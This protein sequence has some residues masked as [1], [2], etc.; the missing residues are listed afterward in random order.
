MEIYDGF[1]HE[2]VGL[3]FR[4]PNLKNDFKKKHLESFPDRENVICT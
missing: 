4:I 3:K 2:G 1:F